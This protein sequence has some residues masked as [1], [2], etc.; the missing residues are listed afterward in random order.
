MGNIKYSW[1][2]ELAE[3]LFRR[4]QK[5]GIIDVS[6]E[7]SYDSDPVCYVKMTYPLFLKILS[8]L[9][10]ADRRSDTPEDYDIVF[11]DLI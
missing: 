7:I 10:E 3:E 4:C 6:A 11:D 9:G 8:A 5:F 2:R 1:D